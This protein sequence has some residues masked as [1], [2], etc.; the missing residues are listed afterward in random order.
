[1][2]STSDT[3]RIDPRPRPVKLSLDQLAVA[4]ILVT[5]PADPRLA[6]SQAQEHLHSLEAEGVLTVGQVPKFIGDIFRVMTRPEVTFS[7]GVVGTDTGSAHYIWA[8]SEFGVV[9]TGIGEE[10]A[11][12]E[13]VSPKFIPLAIARIVDLGPRPLSAP[14]GSVSLAVSR[15]A[16]LGEMVANNDLSGAERVLREPPSI[17]EEWIAPLVRM[18]HLRRI[19]WRA[20]SSWT[21]YTGTTHTSLMVVMDSGD[22]GLWFVEAP[23]STEEVTPDSI[24]TFTPADSQAVWQRIIGLLPSSSKLPPT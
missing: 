7:V 16:S 5:D 22:G 4:G 1:M 3:T 18:L 9:A 14:N 12:F 20:T 13:P 23:E 10:T 17:D 11:E 6:L 15:L 21:D 24:V 2:T 8:T 19:S